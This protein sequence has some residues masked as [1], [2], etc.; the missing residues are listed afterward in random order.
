MR[1]PF[2]IDPVFLG[3]IISLALVIFVFR[4]NVEIQFPL[5][6]LKSKRL[7]DWVY[8]KSKDWQKFVGPVSDVGVVIGFA[9]MV[10][11]VYFLVK[12]LINVLTPSGTSA[13]SI[14]IPGVRVPGSPVFL[15]LVYGIISIAIL[16]IVHEL[17][18]AIVASS[19]GV[20]PKS[21][22]LALLLF[23]P[24]A[25]VEI[26]EKKLS[27]TP[28]RTRLRIFAAGSFANFL[29]AILIIGLAF[30]LSIPARGN[31][32]PAGTEIVS[33]DENSPAFGRL[34][35]GDVLVSVNGKSVLA[36]EEFIS[37]AKELKPGETLSI[38]KSDGTV[39][40][41]VAGPRD[42]SPESGRIGVTTK[43]KVS[44]TMFGKILV[45]LLGLFNWVFNLNIGVGIINLFPF[46]IM[47]GG[48]IFAGVM[49]RLFGEK[50]GKA[51][52]KWAFWVFGPLLAL[53]ILIPIVKAVFF[54]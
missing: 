35:P 44:I 37:L 21:I 51:V 52:S 17:A 25:G 42:D 47:D 4:K 16:A 46:P 10:F 22:A 1:L 19:H 29:T 20:R 26:D 12:S 43:A 31:I 9:G 27:K 11:V 39:V 32:S 49:E 36:L 18:H 50:R 33:V 7:G 13:V 5:F 3:W 41:I 45:W 24:A 53:N 15:P 28:L 8:K 6:L 30:L 40:E 23:I 34:F 38:E 2:G 48:R 14:I 54:S